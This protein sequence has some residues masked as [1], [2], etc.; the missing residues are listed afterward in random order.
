MEQIAKP[1]KYLNVYTEASPNPASL[2]FVINYMLT[3]ENESFDFPSREA[4]EKSPLAA[5]LFDTFPFVE[6]VFIMNN[7][8][9][10]TK[11]EGYDWLEIARDVKLH[12]Q[13]YLEQEKPIFSVELLQENNNLQ[14][15][16]NDSE[17]VKQIKK[18]LEEYVRP[19][20][21]TDGGAIHFRSFE[22]TTGKVVLTLKGSCSGCP[23]SMITLKSGIENLLKRMIP[24]VQEVVAESM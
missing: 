3:P 1:K 16:E 2:K 13:N 7:F 4:A 17:I 20:V 23:S 14:A 21:E 19:A 18:I 24:Q 22:E 12:I 15:T 5:E 6:R 10:V 11:K 9:T 8:I